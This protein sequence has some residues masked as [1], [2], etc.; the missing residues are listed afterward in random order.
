[1]SRYRPPRPK[2]SKFITSAGAQRLKDELD[3]LWLV[4][5]PQVTRAVQEAAAQGDRSE[6]AE[7]IYGKRQLREIDRRVRFLRQRLDGMVIV[8]QGPSDR[9]RVFFGAWVGIEDENGNQAE[10]RVVGPDEIDAAPGYISMD[11]PL[12][13]A[14]MRKGID[15]EVTVESPGG[16]RTWW[17]V[18]IRY[19]Y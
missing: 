11:S 17:I 7:Y 1:M 12:A 14:L 4:Q 15:D 2:G 8:D 5:R 19:E 3:D 9:T 13:R 18:G 10:Y 6:N 16:T